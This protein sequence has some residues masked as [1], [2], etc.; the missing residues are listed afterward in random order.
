MRPGSLLL[1]LL[2]TTGA[3]SYGEEPVPIKQEPRHVLK[4]E[5]AHLRLFDVA[6]EPGYR[7]LYHWHR[8]DGLFVSIESARTVAQNWGAE[9]SRAGF[10]WRDSPRAVRLANAGE[11][12][13]HAVGIRVKQ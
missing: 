1:L 3:A 4:F 7:T 2:C 11:T 12:V 10:Q 9:M 13:F 6:L 5:N 8:N